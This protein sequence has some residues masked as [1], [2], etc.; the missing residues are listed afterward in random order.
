MKELIINRRGR[1]TH[2]LVSFGGVTG[3]G[4]KLVPIPWE[5]FKLRP[6]F[7][8]SPSDS[9]LVLAV[10]KQ[11]IEHAPTLGNTPPPRASDD[12][13]ATL[14]NLA[15][16]YFQPEIKAHRET[17]RKQGQEEPS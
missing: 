8:M 11:R 17:W 1:V 14:L 15:N 2:A 13:Y 5:V 3:V 12:N 16:R 10:S 7:A 6:D 4:E 9:P